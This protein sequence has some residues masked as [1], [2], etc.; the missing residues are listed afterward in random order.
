[1][2]RINTNAELAIILGSGMNGVMPGINIK[3]KISF[4]EIERLKQPTVDSHKG[5]ITVLEIDSKEVI[6]VKGRLHYY[7]GYNEREL[8]ELTKLLFESGVKR[9]VVA[10]ASGGVNKNLE[11]GDL[12]LIKDQIN[13]RFKTPLRGLGKNN[14]NIQFPD[15][16]K[17][18]CEDMSQIAIKVASAQNIKLKK[19]V[20]LGLT[21]PSLETIAEYKMAIVLGADCIGMSTVPEVIMAKYL[22]MRCLGLSVVSNVFNEDNIKETS[23]EAVIETVEIANKKLSLLLSSLIN[24]FA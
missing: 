5:E 2:R 12:L 8:S 22:G 20:Y 1:M 23:F 4:N 21:G 19:G 11:E 10:N 3:Y 18:Y 15:M 17:A 13:F 6:V 24:E 9:L 16:S 14:K 7:E